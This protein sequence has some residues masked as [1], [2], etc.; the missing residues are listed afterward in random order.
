V[1]ITSYRFSDYISSVA[2]IHRVG[3]KLGIMVSTL[4]TS[5]VSIMRKLTPQEREAKNLARAVAEEHTHDENCGH[6]EVAP[7]AETA[8]VVEEAP[9]AEVPSEEVVTEEAV[10]EEVPAEEVVAE[11]KP[12]KKSAPKY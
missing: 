12:K 8:P 2:V 5:E 7:I 4:T 10:A 1:V 9:S 6:L 11:S 3:D